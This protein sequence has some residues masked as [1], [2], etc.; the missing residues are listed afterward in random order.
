LGISERNKLILANIDK[1]LEE[2]NLNLYKF[3]QNKQPR[4]IGGGE[5]KKVQIREDDEVEIDVN[6]LEPIVEDDNKA[7]KGAQTDSTE[8]MSI[9]LRENKPDLKPDRPLRV[10]CI[11]FNTLKIKNKTES[12]IPG[13]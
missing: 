13:L 1:D 4:G 5:K 12:V 3:R 8:F 10:C 6:N 2:Y 7:E 9:V 11:L